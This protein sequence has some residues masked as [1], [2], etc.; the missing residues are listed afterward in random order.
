MRYPYHLHFMLLLSVLLLTGCAASE[1]AP[2]LSTETTL[3]AESTAAPETVETTEN[4]A[5]ELTF[6]TQ[7]D[8]VEFTLDGAFLQTI[9]IEQVPDTADICICD[10]DGDSFPDVFLPE[11]PHSF[12]GHYYHYD[13]AAGQLVLW[14][15]LNFEE[16]GTGWY[17]ECSPDGTLL[18][19]AHS[20]YGTTITRYRWE[21]AAL[22]PAEVTEQYFTQQGLVEDLYRYAED[23]NKILCRRSIHNSYDHYEEIIEYPLYFCMM[24]DAVHVMK[25]TEL[26][27]ELPLGS[28]WDSYAALGAYFEQQKE[29]PTVPLEGAYLREPECYLGTEDYDFDGHADLYIPDTL[30]GD[31]TGTY[32]RYDAE[33]AQFVSWDA[34]NAVG[35]RLYADAE[36]KR[37]TAYNGTEGQLSAQD[38][39]WNEGKLIPLE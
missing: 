29:S 12:R 6:K 28:F 34:L 24:P 4:P 36:T 5:H 37:L 8:G 16:G 35:C 25:N 23:G 19:N 39:Q 27:Q 20:I 22:M 38:Y 31:C 15:A 1:T 30:Q 13:N 33:C 11:S 3:P 7:T 10:Y 17:M 21:Q 32:Y 14:D 9:P 2:S 18:M 26:L